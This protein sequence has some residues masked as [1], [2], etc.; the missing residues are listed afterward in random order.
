MRTTKSRHSLAA[1]LTRG[2]RNKSQQR[3]R[4][5]SGW[6]ST[7]PSSLTTPSASSR[8]S[9]RGDKHLPPVP[10]PQ[11]PRPPGIA[12]GPAD[13]PSE[14]PWVSHKKDHVLVEHPE[15]RNSGSVT[16]SPPLVVSD[17]DGQENVYA[18]G[19]RVLKTLIVCV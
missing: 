6:R 19:A 5:R 14:L 7:I 9:F 11:P 1:S 13:E 12:T 16:F 17:S 18:S 2:D 10:V 15:L 3:R 8:T 4:Q